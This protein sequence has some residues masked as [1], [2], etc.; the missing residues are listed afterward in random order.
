MELF[1]FWDAFKVE[2]IDLYLARF[3]ATPACVADEVAALE[4]VQR[5]DNSFTVE[6]SPVSYPRR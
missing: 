1:R 4:F 2:R 5:S 6:P 3:P